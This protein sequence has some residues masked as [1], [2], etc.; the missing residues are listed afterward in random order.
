MA[1]GAVRQLF[2]YGS[3]LWEPSL[4]RTLSHRSAAPPGESFV[5]EGWERAWNVVSSRT[6]PVVGDPSGVIHRR[7]VLGLVARTGARCEGAVLDLTVADLAT[8]AVREAAYEL[9]DV[10]TCCTFVPRPERTLGSAPVT[11]PLVVEQ[12]YLDECRAGVAAQGLTDAAA[13]LDRS[14]AGLR[15]VTAA[16]I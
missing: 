6:F 10:G 14:L 16:A 4:L 11:E 12:A 2:V 15:V 5:L 9:V 1:V 13:D 3:L 8:L 7:L